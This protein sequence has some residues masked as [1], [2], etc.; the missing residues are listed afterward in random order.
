MLAINRLNCYL[1][2]FSIFKVGN[3]LLLHISVFIVCIITLK[4]LFKTFDLSLNVALGTKIV[5]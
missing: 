2:V 4:L 5:S 3:E 1:D